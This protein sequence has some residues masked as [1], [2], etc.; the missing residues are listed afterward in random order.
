MMA[1][2]TESRDVNTATVSA[3]VSATSDVRISDFPTD[4]DLAYRVHPLP[5]GVNGQLLAGDSNIVPVTE[6]GQVIRLFLEHSKGFLAREGRL[7]IKNTDGLDY[8]DGV[9][10]KEY[11]GFMGKITLILLDED[12][13]PIALC[14]QERVKLHR[15]YNILGVRPLLE[16]DE[17]KSKQDGVAFYPWFHVRDINNAIQGYFRSISVWNG[18]DYA[19]L[20]RVYPATRRPG[21]K[22][23]NLCMVK[24]TELLVTQESD[25]SIVALLNKKTVEHSIGWD[26]T[27]APGVDPALVICTAAIVEDTTS[28]FA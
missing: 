12:D 15:D 20:W 3:E 25:H 4:A 6:A 7:S 17:P 22:A 5:K 26:I 16:G 2:S 21:A 19:A 14:E 28:V 13:K 11:K 27:I 18:N 10:F 9:H 23:A 24:K 1:S 8:A